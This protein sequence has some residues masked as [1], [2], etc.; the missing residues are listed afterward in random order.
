LNVESVS[1]LISGY[2]G[3]G[4]ITR[5]NTKTKSKI[6]TLSSG[7]RVSAI[8]QDSN[9]LIYTAN[10]NNTTLYVYDLEAGKRVGS[11]ATDITCGMAI[12]SNGLIYKGR[13]NGANIKIYDSKTLKLVG[14]F[15]AGGAV[16]D[17]DIGSDGLI[18]VSM[19]RGKAIHIFNPSTLKRVGTISTTGNTW[20]VALSSD[21]IVYSSDLNG[22]IDLYDSKIY[23]KIG[24][25]KAGRVVTIDIDPNNGEIYA[26][27]D[28][29]G[30]VQIYNPTT[31]KNIGSINIDVSDMTLNTKRTGQESLVTINL[32]LRT[33]NQYGKDRQYKKKDYHTGN[34]KLDK[35][36]K[37]KR[38]TFSSTVLVRNLAL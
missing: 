38:D 25:F 17:I 12:D 24:S 36:D 30:K 18:Y 29:G 19:Y 11:K 20:A 13:C 14:S 32:T 1:E 22:N 21:G 37:Y 35:T 6:S 15:S 5:H 23:K 3:H 27:S 26:G 8:V 33:K 31:F 7:V 16:F 34:Y 10:D 2:E 4:N 9:G 28:G